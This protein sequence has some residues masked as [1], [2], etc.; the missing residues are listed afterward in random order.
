MLR[1]ADCWLESSE[2][3]RL[4]G[5]SVSIKLVAGEVAGEVALLSAD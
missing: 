4:L 3:P 1:T 5:A 2:V